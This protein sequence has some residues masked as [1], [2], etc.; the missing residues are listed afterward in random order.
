MYVLSYVQ[1]VI[2]MNL[3][4]KENQT[5]YSDLIFKTEVLLVPDSSV[6]ICI[7]WQ[8]RGRV[9]SIGWVAFFFTRKYYEFGI[10]TH[11]FGKCTYI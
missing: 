2:L 6:M 10:Y 1:V 9:S 11:L 7:G 3:N 4:S 5:I 8:R